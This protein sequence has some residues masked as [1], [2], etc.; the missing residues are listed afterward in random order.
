MLG[1]ESVP[2]GL[3][4]GLLAGVNPLLA[5]HGYLVG[6]VVGALSTST[7]LMSVQA[8]GAMAVII[9]DVP[10]TQTG[11]A[12][13]QEALA[14]LALL[15]GVGMLALGIARLGSLVRFVPSSVLVGFVNAVAINI[16]LSQV[17]EVTGYQSDAGNRVLKALDTVVHPGQI[18]W[19]SVRRRRGHHRAHRAARAH[20]A[21]RAGD[22]RR[23]RPRV[24]APGGARR[25]GHHGAGRPGALGHRHRAAE[26]A[27]AST[28]PRSAWSRRWSCRRS[29]SSSSA[30]SRAP[31]SAAR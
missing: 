28:Y 29:R 2:D 12:R 11:D 17:D 5:L 24:G 19:A 18:Q 27:R 30:S 13:A 31:P 15:T 4:N 16:I 22:G 8:T 23:D 10:Q 6:T 3:A 25:P 20:P 26:P 9:S 14:V 7:V 1:L 21:R